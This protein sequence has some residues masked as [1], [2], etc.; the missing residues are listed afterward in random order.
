MDFEINRNNHINFNN[1]NAARANY[2]RMLPFR[3]VHKKPV[4]AFE[5]HMVLMNKDVPIAEFTL[6][7]Y[8]N[9]AFGLSGL[10]SVFETTDIKQYSDIIQFDNKSLCDFIKY[11]TPYKHRANIKQLIYISRVF[12]LYSLIQYTHLTSLNDT[13]W[14]KPVNSDLTWEQVSLY[15]ND[16]DEAAA[17]TALYGGIHGEKSSKTTPELAT[18]GTF[19]KCWIKD[20]RGDIFLKKAG[21]F[22]G[23]EPYSEYYSQ[24]ILEALEIPHIKYDL[25]QDECL[26]TTCKLFTSEDAGYIPIGR[27]FR[28]DFEEG[29]AYMKYL[30]IE[31][32]FFDMLIADTV[33]MNEDRHL[34]N[35]GFLTDNASGSIIG[36]A[37]LFD[38]NLSLMCNSSEPSLEHLTLNL[39]ILCVHLQKR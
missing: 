23:R 33:M 6:I 25:F 14:I 37:P 17:K 3:E 7:E 12:N 16:F 29:L 18:G 32:N 24:Q 8:K 2:G 35:F 9:K 38:H 20:E 36:F 4:K 30:G 13:F 5:G 28:G 1:D 39:I 31:R 11:R 22:T 27:L 21:G 26:Y 10:F 34:S 15:R 19:P